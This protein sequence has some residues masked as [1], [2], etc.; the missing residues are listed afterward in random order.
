MIRTQ[1]YRNASFTSDV[2]R[3]AREHV[4]N[5]Q[6]QIMVPADLFNSMVD[7]LTALELG[8]DTVL[9]NAAQRLDAANMELAARLVRE[10][11]ES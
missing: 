3:R 10:L 6:L 5:S 1:V 2:T 9:E 7:R 4:H 11:K 8:A